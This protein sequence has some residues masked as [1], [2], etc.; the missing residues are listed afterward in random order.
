MAG[1]KPPDELH[2]VILVAAAQPAVRVEQDECQLRMV[3]CR[4]GA[5]Q[6]GMPLPPSAVCTAEGA[7]DGLLYTSPESCTPLTA[8]AVRCEPGTGAMKWPRCLHT[9]PGEQR[10]SSGAEVRSGGKAVERARTTAVL[11]IHTCLVS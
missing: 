6:P 11:R 10:E 2:Y 9:L 8:T 1:C 5:H 4:T 7:P 3:R